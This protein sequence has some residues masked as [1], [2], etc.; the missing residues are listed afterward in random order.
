M[1][2]PILELLSGLLFNSM[3]QEIKATVPDTADSEQYSPIKSL[4]EHDGKC[5]P[6]VA[7]SVTFS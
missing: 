7:A 3:P 1:M 4:V 5:R 2:A 6:D